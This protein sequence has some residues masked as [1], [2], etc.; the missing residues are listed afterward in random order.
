MPTYKIRTPTDKEAVKQA[1]DLLKEGKPFNVTIKA[2]NPKRSI[3]QN[4]TYWMWINCI[5]DDTGNDQD[6][7][8]EIFKKKFLG[9]DSHELDGITIERPR[10]TTNLSTVEFSAYMEKLQAWAGSELGMTLPNPEDL[11]WEDFY[12]KYGDR[13]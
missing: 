7:L 2:C 9:Y 11:A 6:V 12:N 4:R 5:H 10:S 8:H 3:P 1:I 13:Q